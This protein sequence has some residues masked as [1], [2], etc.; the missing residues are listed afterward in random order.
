MVLQQWGVKFPL[1]WEVWSQKFP[2]EMKVVRWI[3]F[4]QEKAYL[5]AEVLQADTGKSVSSLPIKKKRRKI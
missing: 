5:S 4:Q 2:G 3:H 1:S